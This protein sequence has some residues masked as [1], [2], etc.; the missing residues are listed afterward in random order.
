VDATEITAV[1]SGLRD[2]LRR[3]LAIPAAGPSVRAQVVLVCSAFLLGGVLS[4][5]LF[6][7]VW[8][9]TAA[10][11]DRARAAEL[12]STQS[13]RT[14][15]LQ[16]THAERDLAAAQTALTK[17]RRERRGLAAEA[18]RLRRVNTRAASSLTPGL[19]TIS[20]NADALVRQSA[21]LSSAL[22]TLRDYLQ[23]A[24]GT[25]VDPAFLAAQVSY[26]ARS[27]SSTRATAAALAG[28]AQ[29]AQE[30][31]QTLRRKP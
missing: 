25:G 9:H 5:L 3:Q 6:V 4:A 24:S 31:A 23:N 19:E 16:L 7:G 26:L 29:Q 15:K 2:R 10:E 27:T 17:I 28:E 18:T 1:R 20:G 11:G 12:A 30:S 8:R 22:A 21:K 13:L 14:A